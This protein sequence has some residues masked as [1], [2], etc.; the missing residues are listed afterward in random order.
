MATYNTNL[1]DTTCIH[2]SQLID[3]RGKN[4]LLDVKSELMCRKGDIHSSTGLIP[5]VDIIR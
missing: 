3:M 4:S 2:T 1:L 5:G